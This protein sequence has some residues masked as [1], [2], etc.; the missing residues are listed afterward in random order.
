MVTKI[1]FLLVKKICQ[2]RYLSNDWLFF[3]S[4]MYFLHY[5]EYMLLLSLVEKVNYWIFFKNGQK[6]YIDFSNDIYM[7]I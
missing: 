2:N 5:I 1:L 6:S 4:F 7:L 3:L